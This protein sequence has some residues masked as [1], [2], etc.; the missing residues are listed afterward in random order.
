MDYRIA[1]NPLRR[2][3]AARY[4]KL[5][6]ALLAGALVCNPAWAGPGGHGGGFHG[7]HGGPGFHG[8]VGFR[9]G[10]FHGHSHVG[11]YFGA[12]L[13]WG[14]Y[15]GG[16]YDDPWAYPA[17]PVMVRVAPPPVYIERGLAVPQWY[18][19]A[20]PQGYYPYVK[21]CAIAWRTVPA[22]PTVQ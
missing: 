4:V 12:P 3:G 15:G 18:F 20:S 2:G 7:R 22:Q 5:L 13:Y 14:P 9:G 6:L 10:H 16:W 11:V 8:G 19:C 17:R 21:Q 1:S